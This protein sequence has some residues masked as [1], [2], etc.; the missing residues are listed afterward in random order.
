MSDRPA[1]WW[2]SMIYLHCGWP[3]TGTTSLQAALVANHEVL[4]AAGF[5]YPEDWRRPNGEHRFSD[6]LG[7][8]R[9][10]GASPPGLGRFLDEHAGRD[11]VF[12]S[13]NLT[14]WTVVDETA[15]LLS[16]LAR[17]REAAPVKCIWTLRRADEMLHSQCRHSS[18]FSRTPPREGYVRETDIGAVFAGMQRVEAAV[19]GNV[20]YVKYDRGGRHN[21][22]LLRAF[23][24]PPDVRGRIEA[25][26]TSTP[27]LNAG[28]TQ[29][30]LAAILN[31][32]RLSARIGATL[33][34]SA[35]SAAVRDGLRFDDDRACV[36]S[37]FEER[38]AKHEQVLLAARE[39]GL[40]PYVD[41][42]QD[43][44][45]EDRSPAVDLGHEV[46]SDE[47][48]SRLAS[49]LRQSAGVAGR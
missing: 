48:L 31:A 4:G 39:C 21:A 1:I 7:E 32:E 35:V 45:V 33:D 41:F 30:G 23:D 28:V 25:E 29:K 18:L 9:K 5:L 12:S 47:D 36:V 24:F 46:L 13:E 14:V 3:K 27:R 43:E 19:E 11:I 10:P 42:F 44:E 8:L 6:L 26:L 37:D 20:D 16:L 34:A 49:H 2:R 15:P 38:R 40:E 17:L 22:E